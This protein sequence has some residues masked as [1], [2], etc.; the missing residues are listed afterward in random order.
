METKQP[1]KRVLS[2]PPLNV[3]DDLIRRI[4]RPLCPLN[5]DFHFMPHQVSAVSRMMQT[6]RLIYA[7]EPG[8]GKTSSSAFMAKWV[9]ESSVR[10]MASQTPEER[11]ATSTSSGNCKFASIERTTAEK[12]HALMKHKGL[13]PATKD[14][15]HT[16]ETMMQNN[17]CVLIVCDFSVVYR[18]LDDFAALSPTFVKDHVWFCDGKF[19]SPKYCKSSVKYSHLVCIVTYVTLQRA[20]FRD[21]KAVKYGQPI[22]SKNESKS[23]DGK[24]KKR[25]RIRDKKLPSAL[26]LLKLAGIQRPS[27]G[28]VESKIELKTST[29]LS[30]SADSKSLA[31]S[32]SSKSLADSTSSV[33]SGCKLWFLRKR[34]SAVFFDEAHKIITHRTSLRQ[35]KSGWISLQI[36]RSLQLLTSDAH[37]FVT[38]TPV[39]SKVRELAAY[40][41]LWD[42]DNS[43]VTKEWIHMQA[44]SAEFKALLDEFVLSRSQRQ[45]YELAEKF[46]DLTAMNLLKARRVRVIKKDLGDLDPEQKQLVVN[47]LDGYLSKSSTS[48][49]P[50]A[51]SKRVMAADCETKDDLTDKTSTSTSTSISIGNFIDCV[52][53]IARAQVS[54]HLDSV[55]IHRQ[56][57]EID[58]ISHPQ[59]CWY[60]SSHGNKNGEKTVRAR[61]RCKLERLEATGVTAQKLYDS[62]PMIR[63]VVSVVQRARQ[64]GKKVVIFNSE[65]EQL[66]VISKVLTEYKMHTK[67]TVVAK[68]I[69][70][71]EKEVQLEVDLVELPSIVPL[72]YSGVDSKIRAR[73]EVLRKFQKSPAKEVPVLLVSTKAGGCGLDLSSASIAIMTNHGY[74]PIIEVQ[75]M[76]RISRIGQLKEIE[77]HYPHHNNCPWSLDL[78]FEQ[79]HQQKLKEAG[80]VAPHLRNSKN[81]PVNRDITSLISPPS[82]SASSSPPQPLV[83]PVTEKSTEGEQKRQEPQELQEEEKKEIWNRIASRMFNGWVNRLSTTLTNTVDKLLN[84]NLSLPSWRSSTSSTS[85]M[86]T[87]P[88][89][90]S[91]PMSTS[92]SSISTEA[93]D[94]QQLSTPKLQLAATNNP[95]TI[96]MEEAEKAVSLGAAETTAIESSTAPTTV[97]I[98]KIGPKKFLPRVD[99]KR[100]LVATTRKIT[101]ATGIVAN[102]VGTEERSEKRPRII[103]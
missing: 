48:T 88:T 102:P 25:I 42:P 7:D 20:V 64:E 77:L 2:R 4:G 28:K 78:Y 38:G 5:P 44:D 101:A 55:A 23:E 29:S 12:F 98:N 80:I 24:K 72:I 89:S 57:G 13:I 92:T 36:H 69:G 46:N 35:I 52:G 33:D 58:P 30:D 22:N 19:D 3:H 56:N 74:N 31:D 81:L 93:I 68:K 18:W 83:L 59:R 11:S 39:K 9:A 53:S 27:S 82:A 6:K 14:G 71:E 95:A 43:D 100:K 34:W 84:N 90:T 17:L 79:I 50:D 70:T 8:L 96:I 97:G 32:T 62:S 91:S 16:C 21:A 85:P 60:R 10:E 61:C 63:Y 1:Q 65:V 37:Y 73:V 49:F 66:K 67:K 41:Q 86:S 26:G 51:L 76:K 99:N 47:F 54:H 103:V 45:A 87:P 94:V 15:K 40:F 75:A